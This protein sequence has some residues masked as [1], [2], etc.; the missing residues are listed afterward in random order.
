MSVVF[1]TLGDRLQLCCSSKNYRMT[2]LIR[3]LATLFVF[4]LATC[5]SQ[6]Q[7]SYWDVNAFPEDFL[8]V[9]EVIEELAV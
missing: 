8:G 6:A 7:D 2:S 3:L 1:I 5:F 4:L 9:M